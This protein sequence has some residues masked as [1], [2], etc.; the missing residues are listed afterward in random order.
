MHRCVERAELELLAMQRGLQVRALRRRQVLRDFAEERPLAVLGHAQLLHTIVEGAELRLLR[1]DRCGQRPKLRLLTLDRRLQLR[2][3]RRR[4]VLGDFGEQRAVT[5][6][7]RD[8][9]LDALVH[10]AELGLLL[11][12]RSLHLGP[13]LRRH[14]LRDFGQQRA[15]IGFVRAQA[16]RLPTQLGELGLLPGDRGLGVGQ[17]QHHP[18]D[19]RQLQQ[20]S[21]HP[22]HLSKPFVVFPISFY[23]VSAD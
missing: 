22:P 6:F 17:P 10:A 4:H 9:A 20:R 23:R 8:Q 12:D 21:N 15:V 13:P 5:G 2:Q 19:R 11:R 3:P 16:L 14:V 18:L 7:V 1:L